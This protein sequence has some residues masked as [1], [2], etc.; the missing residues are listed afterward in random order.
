MQYLIKTTLYCVS[1]TI[2]TSC[3]AGVVSIDSGLEL[4]YQ[5][6]SCLQVTA[7]WNSRLE[8]R[9]GEISLIG[10]AAVLLNT[11][12]KGSTLLFL[13]ALIFCLHFSL[14]W[15][16]MHTFTLL[17]LQEQF[18]FIFTG[19]E[20]SLSPDSC[21]LINQSNQWMLLGWMRALSYCVHAN[22]CYPSKAMH[23]ASWVYLKQ[24]AS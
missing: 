1:I 24:N 9:K 8:G 20:A 10:C 16:N 11:E 19:W 15:T 23:K 13:H 12:I 7:Q 5:F 6:V 2:Q 14:Y 22:T 4:I 21:H 18:Y 3:F 17:S